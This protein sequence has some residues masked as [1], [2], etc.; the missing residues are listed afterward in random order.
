MSKAKGKH[1]EK[2]KELS[3]AAS[4]TMSNISSLLDEHRAALSADLK[5]SLESLTSTLDSIHSTIT[6]HR[7]RIDFLVTNAISADERLQYLEDTCSALQKDESLKL[8]VVDLEGRSRRQ[9]VRIIGLPE[10]TEAIFRTEILAS[11]LEL[12]RAHH[13]LAPKPSP[14]EKPQPV[15]LRFHRFQVKDLVICEACKRGPLVYKGRTIRLF[16]DYSPDMLKQR[17]EYR[18]PMAE[19]YKREYKTAHYSTEWG[20]DM[21]PVHFRGD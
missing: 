21:N 19:L 16:D 11:P 17:V 9:N 14:G 18:G 4:I 8:K 15:I 6:D 1:A 13:S 10:S 3:P 20:E 2:D 5:S 7:Q 12:D